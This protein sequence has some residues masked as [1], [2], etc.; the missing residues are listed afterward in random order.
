MD[1]FGVKRA[2]DWHTE[3]TYEDKLPLLAILP[4]KEVPTEKGGTMFA[5]MR[6]AYDALSA[7]K[8]KLLSGLTALNGRQ[9]G[10]RRRETLR[11]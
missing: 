9:T 6:A 4:S 2:T 8:Q 7:E 10:P 1:W 11:R 3:L 5:D